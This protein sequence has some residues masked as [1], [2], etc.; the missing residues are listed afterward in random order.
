MNNVADLGNIPFCFVCVCVCVCVCGCVCVG[1]CV[2]VCVCSDAFYTYVCRHPFHVS[3]C[4]ENEYVVCYSNNRFPLTNFQCEGL[5]KHHRESKTAQT[6]AVWM[7]SA[8]VRPTPIGT[9]GKSYGLTTKT[10]VH[11]L[12][13][14]SPLDPLHYSRNEITTGYIKGDLLNKTY[15]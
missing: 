14:L 15:A 7:L 13:E 3:I 1:V 6:A 9:M 10:A 4:T 5:Q 12:V 2:C 11:S 8:N